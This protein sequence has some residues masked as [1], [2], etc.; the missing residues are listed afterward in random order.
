[1]NGVINNPG[2]LIPQT[3]I[4]DLRNAIRATKQLRGKDIALPMN[5]PKLVPA[6]K[7]PFGIT[8]K[9]DTTITVATGDVIHGT[10]ETV[11][12]AGDLTSFSTG[13]NYVFA[14]I[15]YTTSWQVTLEHD[16]SKPDQSDENSGGTD[17]PALRV[18]LGT[19]FITSAKIYGIPV[20]YKYGNIH[21]AGRLVE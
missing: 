15:Y 4:P 20:Q 19:V 8:R 17:Y 10:T 1:M 9:N 6:Y 11:K 3:S 2:V 5:Q 18:I 16:T 14:T 13:I 21:V 7:G 12:A